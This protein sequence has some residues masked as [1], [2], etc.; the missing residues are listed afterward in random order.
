MKKILAIVIAILMVAVTFAS[1]A[2]PVDGMSTGDGSSSGLGGGVAQNPTNNGALNN[3]GASANTPDGTDETGETG[4]VE[5]SE[6]ESGDASSGG[7]SEID[8][9]GAVYTKNGT[10]VTFGSYPQ[11][12]VS[13]DTLTASLESKA[14]GLP[15]LSDKWKTCNGVSDMVYV[16]VEENGKKYRGIYFTAYRDSGK[17]D[18][19][20]GNNG[21]SI[22]TAYW[23]EYQPITWT[24]LA[25]ENGKAFILA[26]ISLDSQAFDSF[27]TSY[28]SSNIKSWLNA[29]FYNTAFNKLQQAIIADTAVDGSNEK[30]FLLS[31]T[32]VTDKMAFESDR[33][34]TASDY[35]KAMGK[36]VDGSGAGWWLLRD[37]STLK[38]GTVSRV[39]T[40]GSIH[41][42]TPE[43]NS[44][45]IVP[46]LWFTL[47]PEA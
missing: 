5:G 34:K 38:D 26:D 1:C 33:Q 44:G 23:F 30:V 45:G 4:D 47:T 31:S 37:V 28:A 14:G 7:G 20:Q 21:Y 29:D 36:Y 43:V 10:S 12:L 46:A 18:F 13:D 9:A 17:G 2:S 22:N 25:E 39:K 32:E 27:S 40:D 42:I 11:A 35:S 15:S 24:V 8:A 6:S 19:Y 16:D 3:N 41:Y